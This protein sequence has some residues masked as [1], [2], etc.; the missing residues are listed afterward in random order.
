MLVLYIYGGFYHLSSVSKIQGL[1]G[2][3]YTYSGSTSKISKSICSAD[4]QPIRS[5][6]LLTAIDTLTKKGETSLLRKL[7]SVERYRQQVNKYIK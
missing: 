1:R 4:R 5:D 3:G 2:M 7:I 6:V